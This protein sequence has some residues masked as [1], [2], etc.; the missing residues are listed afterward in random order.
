MLI[1]LAGVFFGV[2][3]LRTFGDTKFAQAAQPPISPVLAFENNNAKSKM[4]QNKNQPTR[5]PNFP[6]GELP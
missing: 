1:I 4:E 5:E 3:L 2:Q 6:E